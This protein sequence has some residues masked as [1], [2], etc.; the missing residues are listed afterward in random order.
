MVTDGAHPPCAPPSLPRQLSLEIQA[1]TSWMSGKK[2]TERSY[3]WFFFSRR[4]SPTSW[5]KFRLKSPWRVGGGAIEPWTEILFCEWSHDLADGPH[6]A[7]RFKN[8]PGHESVPVTDGAKRF[9]RSRTEG[10]TKEIIR[11]KK[12]RKHTPGSQE[13]FNFRK[14]ITDSYKVGYW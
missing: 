8:L 1:T 9:I 13:S 4:F 2:R 7:A 6:R 5:L 11:E 12:K 10:A 14:T 3:I